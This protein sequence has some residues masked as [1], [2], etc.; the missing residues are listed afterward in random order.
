MTK[1]SGSVTTEQIKALRERTGAGVIECKKA[2]IEAG[3]DQEQAVQILREKGKSIAAQKAGR[4]AH[5][6][7]IGSYVHGG[8]IGVL[9]EINCETDFVAKTDPFKSFVQEICLQ[10]ASMNPRYVNREEVPP[11]EIGRTLESLHEEIEGVEAE[12]AQPIQQS[13]MEQF[14]RERVL[15]D[16]PYVRDTGKTVQDLLTDTVSTLR[17]NIVI[18][19]FVRFVLGEDA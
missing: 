16:Q 10:I 13:H 3:G 18:R 11:E 15:L 7:L 1:S 14:Y 12:A 5:Q 9:V 19:R 8:R 6:G 17:E 2:L 4:A